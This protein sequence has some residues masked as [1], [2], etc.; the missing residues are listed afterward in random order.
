VPMA[1]G[2]IVMVDQKK[3]GVG[4]QLEKSV[5]FLSFPATNQVRHSFGIRLTTN[6]LGMMSRTG[7]GLGQQAAENK[8]LWG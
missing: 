5:R 3:V 8:R 6:R 1:W 4:G 7:S 2:L